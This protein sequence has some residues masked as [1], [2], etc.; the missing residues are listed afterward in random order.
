MYTSPRQVVEELG[1]ENVV[2]EMGGTLA[3]S[4]ETWLGN[5]LV[6]VSTHNY[7]DTA[8][9]QPSIAYHCTYILSGVGKQLPLLVKY[10]SSPH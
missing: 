7:I 9:S 4:H 10:K 6:S 2:Q 1:G 5:R 3:Y 8:H